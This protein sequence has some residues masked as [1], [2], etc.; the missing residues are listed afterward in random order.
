MF[1]TKQSK[2]EEPN[3]T[4]HRK[5]ALRLLKSCR[6]FV[7]F[8]SPRADLEKLYFNCSEDNSYSK[9]MLTYWVLPVF[10]LS[11]SLKRN[12][13]LIAWFFLSLTRWTCSNTS[14]NSCK[15]M[16]FTGVKWL[17]SA[18]ISIFTHEI[19]TALLNAK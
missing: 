19:E 6:Y 4:V 18:P 9:N 7:V 10:V 12:K 14:L 3:S 15:S 5:P 1:W 11:K 2:I 17:E 8:H 13:I 16:L